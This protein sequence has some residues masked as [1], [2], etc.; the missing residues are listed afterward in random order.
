MS[1]SS[2][3]WE[4]GVEQLER[5]ALRGLDGLRDLEELEADLG[6]GTE[7]LPG[8]D[9]EQERVADLPGGAGDGDVGGHPSRLCQ[10]SSDV[11][12]GG[13]SLQVF[14]IR[15]IRVGVHPTWFLILFLFILWLRPRFEDAIITPG[16]GFIADGDRLAAVL[17]L[18]RA[19]RVRARVRGAPRGDRGRWR[20]PLLLR[21]LHARDAR[22][23]D[24]RRGVPRRRGR[25]GG[26]A[27]ADARASAPSGSPCSA[28]CCST[29]RCSTTR[30]ARCSRS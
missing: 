6:V 29:P 17:R 11:F 30:P 12:G 23:R 20:R 7:Q 8:G 5:G 15:G 22:L 16:Q 18:D 10:P 14:R 3:S 9:S 26:H 21:R 13:T 2:S 28:T 24:A 27:A 25:P 4:G 1:M 19:A